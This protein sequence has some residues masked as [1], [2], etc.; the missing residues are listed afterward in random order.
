MKKLSTALILLLLCQS[1][2]FANDLE[3]S[4]YCD[5]YKGNNIWGLLDFRFKNDNYDLTIPYADKS[6]SFNIPSDKILPDRY[7]VEK[8]TFNIKEENGLETI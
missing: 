4:Y 6:V 5:Y 1:L 8:G 7:Y 2:F 3:T